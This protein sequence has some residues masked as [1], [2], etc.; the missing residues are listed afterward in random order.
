MNKKRKEVLKSR[1]ME[2]EAT[3]EFL[4]T[5]GDEVV[6]L[7][8]SIKKMVKDKRAERE[9]Q[10]L[11]SKRLKTNIPNNLLP[12]IIKYTKRIWQAGSTIDTEAGTIVGGHATDQDAIDFFKHQQRFDFGKVVG[13]LDAPLKEAVLDSLK[14]IGKTEKEIFDLLDHAVP[15]IM[16]D[17]HA[18]NLV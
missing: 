1:L 9:I 8:N 11:I 6:A 3:Q 4:A 10:E 15:A 17:R 18:I 5:Y 2:R 7:T 13:G 16:K 14:G 12:V